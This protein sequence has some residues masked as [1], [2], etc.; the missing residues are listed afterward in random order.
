M[1]FRDRTSSTL[2]CGVAPT[3]L[4]SSH[5]PASVQH[6][7]EAIARVEPSNLFSVLSLR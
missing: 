2:T 6:I 3:R 7:V 5:D 1:A 4:T